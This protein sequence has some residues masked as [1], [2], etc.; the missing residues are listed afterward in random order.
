VLE[1][2]GPNSFEEKIVE[3]EPSRRGV[4]GLS[5]V[6]LSTPNC[7]GELN[8][9]NYM[10]K[11]GFILGIIDCE[12]IGKQSPKETPC[13]LDLVEREAK[14]HALPRRIGCLEMHFSG[15]DRMCM[16]RVTLSS[17]HPGTMGYNHGSAIVER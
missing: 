5:Q 11:V 4:C 3:D 16:R 8:G 2:I 7:G 17:I 1:R 12:M 14:K 6:T 15:E 10:K 9:T 13:H